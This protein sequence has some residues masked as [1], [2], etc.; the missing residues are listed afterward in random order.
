LKGGH[1]VET[2]EG[3]GDFTDESAEG[4]FLSRIRQIETLFGPCDRHIKEATFTHDL[5]IALTGREDVI[6]EIHEE[7]D[8]PFEPLASV[9]A[10][11]RD[12][13][14]GLFRFLGNLGLFRSS[15]IPFRIMEFIG[16]PF[17]MKSFF[18]SVEIVIV[19]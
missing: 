14:L 16:H 19:S 15:F 11:E 5:L 13:G 10:G 8:V 9:N 7:Y 18:H 2:E 1:I 3:A 17:D 12:G 6:V 4:S